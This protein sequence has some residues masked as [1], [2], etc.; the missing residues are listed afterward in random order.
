MILLINICREKLHELE[1]VK[2]V[3]EILLG[4]GIEFK[5]VHYSDLKK[6]EIFSYSKVII[7]GTSLKD[8]YF[9]K[10]K[11]KFNWIKDFKGEILGICGG[12][13]LILL[14]FGGK[15]QT[16]KQIGLFRVNFEK[17]FLGVLGER[18]V[19][20]LHSKFASSEEF[21]VFAFLGCP[22]AVKHKEREIYGVLF[23][24][25]VRNRD[26]ILNFVQRRVA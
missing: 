10:D 5:T 14:Q 20:L 6:S 4:V 15:K 2:P 24:P 11:N 7:C 16:L 8:N 19:Y 25:E 22:Q 21:D 23:H 17:E 9:L 3:E 13:H 12:M 1:F 26:L 18:E